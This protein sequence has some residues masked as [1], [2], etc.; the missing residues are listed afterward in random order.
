MNGYAELVGNFLV[1]H[2]LS[3]EDQ[4]LT[5]TLRKLIRGHTGIGLVGLR[6]AHED[7]INLPG[8][9]GEFDNAGILGQLRLLHIMTHQSHHRQPLGAV[10]QGR[11]QQ[12]GVGQQYGC[13][14]MA[15][16]MIGLVGRSRNVGTY[17]MGR[18]AENSLKPLGHDGIFAQH[19]QFLFMASDF[20]HGAG[21]A[22]QQFA[23][24]TGMRGQIGRE[25]E[26]V[27]KD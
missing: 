27:E 3:H 1:L 21:N 11:T 13:P 9:E 25:V 24:N 14:V 16:K 8:A 4:H 2:A 5:L 7:F 26:E 6:S 18:L 22:H 10:G 19:Y 17:K 12:Q 15:H 23:L 20:F